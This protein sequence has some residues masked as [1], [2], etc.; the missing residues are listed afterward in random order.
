MG[1]GGSNVTFGVNSDVWMIS[2]ISKERRNTSS[3]TQSIIVSKLCKR[4]EFGPVV[5]LVVTIYVEVLLESLIHAFGLSITF[6]V[7]T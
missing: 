4:C 1:L 5:L 2:L 6:G 3:S 7:V